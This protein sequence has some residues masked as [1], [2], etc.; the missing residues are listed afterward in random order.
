MRAALSGS[1]NQS[2]G[3]HLRKVV[4][5][6]VLCYGDSNTWGYMPEGQPD[7]FHMRYPEEVRWPGVLQQE[8]GDDFFV[9]EEGLNGRTTSFDEHGFRCRNGV[10]YLEGCLQTHEPLD[11]VVV[12]LGTND[13][14]KTICGDAQASAESIAVLLDEIRAAHVGPKGTAPKVL[15]V[16]PPPFGPGILFSPFD[17]DYDGFRTIEASMK[18]PE[19]YREKA[20]LF[21]AEF[22]DAAE[23]AKTGADGVHL[24][25]EGHAALGQAVADKIRSMV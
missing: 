2:G 5:K 12:M 16:S 14:K 18:L 6:R 22:L 21:G 1:A 15:L 20:A 17:A 9:I 10:A 24:T 19:L 4:K 8:L 25:A 3:R 7:G 11:I 13:L 23:Y